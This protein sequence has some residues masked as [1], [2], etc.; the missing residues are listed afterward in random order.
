MHVPG[1]VR[2]CP[3]IFHSSRE[4]WLLPRLQQSQQ[5][6]TANLQATILI[7]VVS[8]KNAVIVK[9]PGPCSLFQTISWCERF[10][11]TLAKAPS[12][13]KFLNSQWSVDSASETARKLSA[14][15]KQFSW[16]ILIVLIVPT[17]WGILTVK[18][19]RFRWQSESNT[20][21][22]E[23]LFATK[24]FLVAIKYFFSSYQT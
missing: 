18:W 4:W 9:G 21:R 5:G 3:H 15:R 1:T 23:L 11:W 10:W 20:R 24:T 16:T 2:Q 6:S 17:R 12:L 14:D 22:A 8:I 19:Y 7:Y 13:G